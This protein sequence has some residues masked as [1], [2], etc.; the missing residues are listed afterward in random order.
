MD[1]DLKETLRP[2]ATKLS[3]RIYSVDNQIEALTNERKDLA[4]QLDAFKTLIQAGDPQETP[5]SLADL[6]FRDAVRTLL[7]DA[8]SG[9]TTREI[10]EQLIERGYIY[11]AETPLPIRVSNEMR[12]MVL[13][14]IMVKEGK[15]YLLTKKG[16][17][18]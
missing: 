10:R 3:E 9:L 11:T 1:S 2:F 12:R 17:N 7:R 8:D 14:A 6:G 16:W 15:K 13:Q 18:M 5:S 4:R